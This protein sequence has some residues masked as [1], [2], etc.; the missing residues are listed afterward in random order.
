[1][2]AVD[3]VT[4]LLA[5]G[6]LRGV[7]KRFDEAGLIVQEGLGTLG[8]GAVQLRG[9]IVHELGHA[10]VFPAGLDFGWPGCLQGD[11]RIAPALEVGQRFQG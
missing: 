1:M 4:D 3:T 6:G 11:Q 10:A 2:H 8:E 7:V 9:V 5:R